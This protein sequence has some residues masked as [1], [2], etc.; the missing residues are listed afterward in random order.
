MHHQTINNAENGG[1]GS[2]AGRER[3]HCC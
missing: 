3:E 2:D 1:G